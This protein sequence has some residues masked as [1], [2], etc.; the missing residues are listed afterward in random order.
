MVHLVSPPL[1]TSIETNIDQPAYA[2]Y[3][4]SVDPAKYSSISIDIEPIGPRGPVS[5]LAPPIWAFATTTSASSD[6]VTAVFP[7]K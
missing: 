6:S 2:Q 5:G 3:R 4:P 7:A 1:P